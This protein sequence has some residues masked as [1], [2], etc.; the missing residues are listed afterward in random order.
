MDIIAAQALVPVGVRGQIAAEIIRSLH[1]Q[2][3][4]LS[5]AVRD[6]VCQLLALGY[7]TAL[8]RGSRLNRAPALAVQGTV[9]AAAPLLSRP[10]ELMA[11]SRLSIA[12]DG[13]M[14]A[15]ALPPKALERYCANGWCVAS[16]SPLPSPEARN[17]SGPAGQHRSALKGSGDAQYAGLRH[18]SDGVL[19]LP[20]LT[21][22]RGGRGRWGDGILPVQ[23]ADR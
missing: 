17:N 18:V 12:G 20:Y 5:H 10:F 9:P 14:G 1:D 19:F 4:A 8:A 21:K 3:I 16:S 7:S 13:G 23:P 15:S 2:F 6:K 22:M 11:A